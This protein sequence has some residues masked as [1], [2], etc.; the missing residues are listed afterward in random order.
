MLPGAKRTQL[1]RGI[2]DVVERDAE[3]GKAGLHGGRGTDEEP[4][5]RE[6]VE[7]L[8][9]GDGELQRRGLRLR[10]AAQEQAQM[11]AARVRPLGGGDAVSGI[12]GDVQFSRIHAQGRFPGDGGG[13]GKHGFVPAVEA[14][15]DGVH[16]GCVDVRAGDGVKAA[17]GRTDVRGDEQ[18]PGFRLPDDAAYVDAVRANAVRTDGLAHFQRMRK[19]AAH[20]IAH[21]VAVGRRVYPL[22]AG[23]TVEHAGEDGGRGLFPRGAVRTG[24]FAL[25]TGAGD[26]RQGGLRFRGLVLDAGAEGAAW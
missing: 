10:H 25:Q 20:G 24:Q 17:G 7:A 3:R 23:G 15:G 22:A 12:A 6:A 2:V 1:P 14:G 9:S 19:R 5:V 4:A 11:A 18:L 13:G 8:G 16:G 26:E 21:A